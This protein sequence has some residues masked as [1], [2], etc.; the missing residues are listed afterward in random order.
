MTVSGGCGSSNG[1]EGGGLAGRT[2]GARPEGG[3][4]ATTVTTQRGPVSSAG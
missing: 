2:A 4:M 3:A 1:S